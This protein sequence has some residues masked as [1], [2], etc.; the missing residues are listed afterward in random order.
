MDKEISI[1]NEIITNKIYLIR[2]QKVM[3]DRDLAEL[4]GAETKRLNEQVK[5]NITRFPKDF[6]FQLTKEEWLNLRSQIATSNSKDKKIKTSLSNKNIKLFSIVN[7]SSIR[8]LH[9][10]IPRTFFK[11]SSVRVSRSEVSRTFSH[12]SIHSRLQRDHSYAFSF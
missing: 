5:R 11:F 4:Y 8:V 12:F 9:N 7:F 6:M 3:F 2:N 1:P 10:E